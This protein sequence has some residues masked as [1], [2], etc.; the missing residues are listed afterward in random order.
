[1]RING[2]IIT[3]LIMLLVFLFFVCQAIFFTP[4][5]RMMPM[6]IG[7]PGAIISFCQVIIE[8]KT[9]D[10]ETDGSPLFSGR[11]LSILAWLAAFIIGIAALG[12]AFGSSPVVAG[13]LYFVAKE[14]LRTA[15]VA[16]IFCFVFM[17]G[18]FERLMNMQLFEGLL[19]QYLW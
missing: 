17:Y 5:A 18:L 7:V 15:L 2:R 1:M 10:R 3:S 6:L 12:F 19:P 8:L 9:G 13:Y 11:E 4:A 14:R 16:G